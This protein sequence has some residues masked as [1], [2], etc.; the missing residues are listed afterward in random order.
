M[1][2]FYNNETGFYEDV[3]WLR[4]GIWYEDDNGFL[5]I[6]PPQDAIAECEGPDNDIMDIIEA[7]SREG[8]IFDET[9]GEMLGLMYIH[10]FLKRFSDYEGYYHA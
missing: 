1:T 5:Y 3:P 7:H 6:I 2:G 9:Y 4:E 10:D 8:G